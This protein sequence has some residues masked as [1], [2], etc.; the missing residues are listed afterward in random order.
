MRIGEPSRVSARRRRTSL[1]VLIWSFFSSL[2]LHLVIQSIIGTVGRNGQA[3]QLA[4]SFDRFDLLQPVTLRA[5]KCL[6]PG[7]PGLV[8]LLLGFLVS[9]SLYATLI[10]LVVLLSLRVHRR[11][12]KKVGARTGAG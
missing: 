11:F 12:K 4:R 2:L 9:I 1:R 5:V 7:H 10:A 6:A 8:Q 3:A